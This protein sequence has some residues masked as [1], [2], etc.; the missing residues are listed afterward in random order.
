M[1]KN[2]TEEIEKTKEKLQKLESEQKKQK[3]MEV[4]GDKLPLFL[5]SQG[6]VYESPDY[7]SKDL[8]ETITSF[9]QL[10]EG[11]FIHCFYHNEF[12]E[13]ISETEYDLDQIDDLIKDIQ[14]KK[15][16]EK[17]KITITF[18]LEEYFENE[19][20]ALEYAKD[21]QCYIRT[22]RS[23]FAHDIKAVKVK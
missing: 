16:P 2:I 4:W 7:Y 5:L 23:E 9:V 18:S 3:E 13:G 6:Y 19:E 20:S 22:L 12:E 17:Y 8:N 15:A 11:K 14:N 1:A 10:Y 21:R